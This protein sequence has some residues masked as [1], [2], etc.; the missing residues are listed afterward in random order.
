MKNKLWPLVWLM[1]VS[2]VSSAEVYK[3]RDRQGGAHYSD[4][5][6]GD[7][8]IL[9]VEAGHAYFVVQRVF[10]GDTVQ[11]SNGQKVRLLGINTP[12][13]AG[14]YKNAEAGG[15]AAKAWLSRRLLQRKVRL[16]SDAEA[17]DKYGRQLAHLFAEDGEHINLA[18]VGQGLAA[19]AIHPPNLKYADVLFKAQQAAERGKLGIWGRPE[20]APL[21][22]QSVSAENYKGWKRITGRILRIKRTAKYSYLQFSDQVAL[23]IANAE[24]GLFPALQD[25]V[26]RQVE[27]RGW[28]VKHKTHFALQLRHPG[29]LLLR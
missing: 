23:R 22:F 13:V 14:R 11:L 20:Y 7:A 4:R 19:V 25:Y 18:L 29:D 27:A 5:G 12:E 15:E 1:V 28:L 24:L 3:W 16:E 2:G 26:G 17:R 21:P 8:E 9:P 10:D 6:R